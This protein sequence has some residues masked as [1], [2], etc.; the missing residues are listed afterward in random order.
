MN[1]KGQALV[2]FV[3]ILP[4][5]IVILFVVYDFGNIFSK[6]NELENI[7]SDIV[8]LYRNDTEK[9]DIMA[10]YSDLDIKFDNYKDKYVKITIKK[11]INIITPGLDKIIGKDYKIKVERVVPNA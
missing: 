8:D 6:K 9:A 3:L 5:F 7:S 1:K 2:E 11:N 4:I 10:M